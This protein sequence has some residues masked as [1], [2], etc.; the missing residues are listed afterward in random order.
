MITELQLLQETA[1]FYCNDT[2]QTMWKWQFGNV[3]KNIYNTVTVRTFYRNHSMQFTSKKVMPTK[4]TLTMEL[5]VFV[6]LFYI[7][8]ILNQSQIIISMKFILIQ[9]MSFTPEFG[10]LV[11]VAISYQIWY[12]FHTSGFAVLFPFLL[13]SIVLIFNLVTE[14]S[15]VLNYF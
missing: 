5:I 9:G 12:D 13:I 11:V 4:E 14:R 7:F 2:Y 1:E 6:Y 3:S 15:D 10:M 8:R